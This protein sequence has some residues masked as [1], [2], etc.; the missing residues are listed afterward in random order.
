MLLPLNAVVAAALVGVVLAAAIA[1]S[2][3]VVALNLATSGSDV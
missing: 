2:I 3:V 1:T